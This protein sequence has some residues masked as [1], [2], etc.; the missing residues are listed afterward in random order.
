MRFKRAIA[1]FRAVLTKWALDDAARLAASLAFFTS[2]SLAPLLLVATAVADPI[3]GREKVR[4]EVLLRARELVGPEGAEVVQTVLENAALPR[5]S[6]PAA[7]LGLLTLLFGVTNVFLQLQRALNQ[8][9]NVA[10]RPE[11]GLKGMLRDR[12]FALTL[13]LGVGLLLLASPLL[14]LFLDSAR[15]SLAY[16]LPDTPWLWRPLQYT[17]FLALLTL[18]FAAIFRVIPSA[19]IKWHDVWVGA[20]LTAL[21]F[22]LGTI[23]MGRYLGGSAVTTA[24]GAAGSLMALLLW[25]FVSAQLLFFGAEFTQVY[26]S[27]R[28]EG[29]VPYDYAVTQVEEDARR[30][31]VIRE[32]VV[33]ARGEK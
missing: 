12:L 22:S 19:K 2:L 23:L 13:A 3:L 25:L 15:N 21:L 31:E 28:G 11:R 27:V 18:A 8:I 10:A 5:A 29:I 6:V 30:R 20:L 16:V 4:D 24:Y 7:A 9:W 1:F 33:R 26:A 17:F 32:F 14:S